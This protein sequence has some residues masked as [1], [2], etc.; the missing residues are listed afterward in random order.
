MMQSKSSTGL[1]VAIIM[2]GNGRWATV[3]GLPRVSGH[4][5]G[6]TAVRRVVEHAPGL[7]IRALTLYAFSSDNWAR[8]PQEVQSIFWIIRA[9]LR[10]EC[11][12]L[13]QQGARLEVIGRRDRIPLPLL[14]EIERT[15]SITAEGGSLHLRIAIDYSA[16]TSIA[17]ALAT[18][19]S[20]TS[21]HQ[22]LS[23][24]S[25]RA[26]VTHTLTAGSGNVDLL[27]RT[28]GEQRL[29]DFL[30]WE[31]A[32]AELVFTPRMWPDF[33]ESDLAAAL[34]DF[35]HRER[36]FGAIPSSLDQSAPSLMEN[37]Q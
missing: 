3:R 24:E 20:Q 5:A 1:H 30:L 9:F 28:G 36:R 37:A 7:G 13:R 19:A 34:G 17:V 23:A 35:N 16:Q 25:V 15:E 2:D 8:P 21:R 29:S 32:Y 33:D 4:R 6:V 22:P 11:E 12:R 31:S 26:I 27:I 18:A 14:R 10:L